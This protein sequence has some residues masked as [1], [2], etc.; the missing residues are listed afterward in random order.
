MKRA[1]FM[2]G[3]AASHQGAIK[4]PQLHYEQCCQIG[5]VAG[6]DPCSCEIYLY[7]LPFFSALFYFEEIKMVL[8]NLDWHGNK[9]IS[10]YFGS[11]N[12]GLV[13]VEVGG[14]WWAF[15]LEIVNPIWQHCAWDT[16]ALISDVN[17]LAIRLFIRD[18]L[19]L[20]FLH[21]KEK[22]KKHNF[23]QFSLRQTV[24]MSYYC[25]SRR[26]MNDVQWRPFSQSRPNKSNTA[27]NSVY[28]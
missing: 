14:F 27:L 17:K 19:P 4:E 28:V 16:P 13:F 18:L 25:N 22:V 9:I 2:T 11:K 6:F 24:D 21:Q 7:L 3:T 5:R 8:I 26:S 12:F 20:V 15:G 1:G 10:H 23:I